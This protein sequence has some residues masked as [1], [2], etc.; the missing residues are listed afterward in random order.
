MSSPP[1]MIRNVEDV[2]DRM[3]LKVKTISQMVPTDFI[4]A[5]TCAQYGIETME[6]VLELLEAL[7]EEEEDDAVT[8]YQM[9]PVESKER[10][11]NVV[12]Q[13]IPNFDPEL[14]GKRGQFWCSKDFKFVHIESCIACTAFFGGYNKNTCTLTC[15]YKFSM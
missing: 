2:I 11:N 4:D 8:A 15:N 12:S 1:P 10:S 13:V 14:N 5:E 6:D 7:G 3:G 9:I